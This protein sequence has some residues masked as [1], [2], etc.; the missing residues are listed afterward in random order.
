[1][2]GKRVGG[3]SGCVV[4][5]CVESRCV[6]SVCLDQRNQGVFAWVCVDRVFMVR[7][8]LCRESMGVERVGV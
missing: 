6:K 4:S 3:E 5:G 1:M 8:C 7:G 2:G